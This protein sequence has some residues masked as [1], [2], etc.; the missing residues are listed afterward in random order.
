MDKPKCSVAGCERP[1]RKRH[2]CQGHYRRWR[3]TGDVQADVPFKTRRPES[4]PLILTCSIEGCLSLVYH[5]GWCRPH[6]R[7]WCEYGDPLGISPRALC[8]WPEGCDKEVWVTKSRSGMCA[9]HA[10]RVRRK[11]RPKRTYA[12]NRGYVLNNPK[13]VAAWN[14]KWRQANPWKG[15][16]YTDARRARLLGQFVERVYRSV[17]FKRDKGICGICHKK[18][19]PA[20][21]HLDHIIPI[22]RGGEHSYANVQVSHPF[23][24]T[25][26]GA[27]LMDFELR[28]A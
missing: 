16:E 10:D 7:R 12:D 19:D 8:A 23:C 5:R 18:V 1:R 9:P 14:K 26:K 6:Y 24:N 11:K 20:K 17:V 22:S 3:A 21:W 13:K 28:L 4:R 15:R 2:W 25:S 27:R